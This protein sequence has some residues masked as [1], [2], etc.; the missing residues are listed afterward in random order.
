MLLL[1]QAAK[2]LLHPHQPK[3]S[4]DGVSLVELKHSRYISQ[5]GSTL[6]VWIHTPPSPLSDKHL[7][8]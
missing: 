3:L 1:P 5:P 6:H 7:S 2:R 4:E 8:F